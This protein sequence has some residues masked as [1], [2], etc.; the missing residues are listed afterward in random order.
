MKCDLC[1]AKTDV[2]YNCTFTAESLSCEEL[3]EKLDA[4]DGWQEG[5]AMLCPDCL[6]K[7]EKYVSY[8]GTIER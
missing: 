1:G 2:I 3:S 4:L 7:W 8:H 6:K 5:E